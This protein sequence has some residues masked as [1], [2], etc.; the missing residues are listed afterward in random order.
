MSIKEVLEMTEIITGIGVAV[1]SPI[2][3]ATV[4]LIKK[5]IQKDRRA[6]CMLSEGIIALQKDRFV[7]LYYKCKEQNGIRLYQ[8][9]ILENMFKSYQELG[10]N[11]YIEK[12]MDEINHMKTLD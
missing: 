7:E 12:I 2:I 9:D 11:S 6:H 10:G 1:L 4:V 5:S 3:L 8:R